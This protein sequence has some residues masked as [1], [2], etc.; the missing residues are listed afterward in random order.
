MS[1]PRRIAVKTK[2]PDGTYKFIPQVMPHAGTGALYKMKKRHKILKASR[3]AGSGKREDTCQAT[4]FERHCA[5][6]SRSRKHRGYAGWA[7]KTRKLNNAKH[8]I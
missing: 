7:L 4:S 6:R 8:T 3:N 1:S 5:A 2:Q